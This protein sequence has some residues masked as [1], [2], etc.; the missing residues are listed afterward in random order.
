ML[1]KNTSITTQILITLAGL[2]LFMPFLGRVHLFDWDEINFAEAAREMIVSKNYLTVQ[3]NY[4]PF[5]EKPPL[6]IWM[7]VLSMKIF[8]VNEMAARLPNAI[9]GIATLLA[10]YNAG[11]KLYSHQFGLI[12]VLSYVGC[13]LPFFYFKSGIIDPWFNLFIFLGVYFFSFTSY[14]NRKGITLKI[15]LS[16]ACIG[17]AI[18]TKGPVAFLIF[19]MTAF[20]F[21]ALNKFKLNISI[22]QLLLYLLIVVLVGGFW[23]LI[24][25]LNGNYK[26]IEDFIIYQIR[27]FQTKDAG[28]GGFLL[29]HFVVLLIGVFPGSIF[30]F[31]S[32]SKNNFS[33]LT[34]V[35]FRKWMLV[36]FW[37]VLILFTIVKTKILHYSSLCYFPLTFLCADT[38]YHLLQR[39]I[40]WKKYFSIL[41]LFIGSIFGIA[42]MALPFV[43][44]YKMD[45]IK[46]GIIKDDFAVA[47]LQANPGWSG[48]ESLLGLMFI[49]GLIIAIVLILKQKI[50]AGIIVLFANSIV[51]MFITM[52]VIAPK[53]EMYS[54]NA[55]IEFYQAH[56]NE[57]CYFTTMDFKSYA[58]LFYGKI[59]KPSSPDAYDEKWLLTGNVDKTCYFI[60][61]IDNTK[62]LE[63]YPQVKML[64]EKNGFVFYE[65]TPGKK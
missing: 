65:R 26:L 7:Q 10:I 15:I 19:F 59:R 22:P 58:H 61:K 41:I 55:A 30:A 17:L 8:G 52:S 18:L 32:F 25:A 16:A 24:E 60:T 64:Y 14:S 33:E 49:V 35:Q 13:L 54:Q 57:D 23:F 51:F 12:W 48:Y 11:K 34:Q 3:I 63:K 50:K 37:F 56:Q 62:T 31:Q 40:Y 45:I 44:K 38:V 9:C 39:R 28:H 27:L 4:L 21:R 2:I 20:I 36:L 42:I 43:D 6:F 1:R 5:W 53:I 46:S 29:Y 47:N